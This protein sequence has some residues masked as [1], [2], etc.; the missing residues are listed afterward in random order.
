VNWTGLDIALSV[1]TTHPK[2][3]RSKITAVEREENMGR[4]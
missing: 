2:T 3:Q 4:V 1:S